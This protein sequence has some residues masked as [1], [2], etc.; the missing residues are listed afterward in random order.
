MTFT[1]EKIRKQICLTFTKE[2]ASKVEEYLKQKPY[3]KLSSFLATL[4]LEHVDK[5]LVGDKDS[6]NLGAKEEVELI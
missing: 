4:L 5:E 1:N 3:I 2:E 6:S